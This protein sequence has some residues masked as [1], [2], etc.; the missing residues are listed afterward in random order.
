MKKKLF[1]AIAAL[2]A[3][4]SCLAADDITSVSNYVSSRLA[5]YPKTNA[6]AVAIP[7]NT[8]NFVEYTNDFVTGS[9]V[10][11]RAQRA[12]VTVGLVATTAGG[13][14]LES[15]AVYGY[16]RTWA[17]P[18]GVTNTISRRLQPH[19]HFAVT[20]ATVVPGLSSLIYD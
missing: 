16:E 12:T 13:G 3:A 20:N 6:A 10:L 5:P 15:N 8:A 19:S 18:P 9:N 11:L 1:A 14:L 7:T 4:G 2:T 17:S